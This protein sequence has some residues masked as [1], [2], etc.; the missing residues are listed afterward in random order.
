MLSRCP[1]GPLKEYWTRVPVARRINRPSS[2]SPAR[3]AELG[4]IGDDGLQT[5]AIHSLTA[6]S[7]CCC[8]T[9]GMVQWESSLTGL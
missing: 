7:F 6:P 8:A 3:N 5:L 4:Q 9:T 1:R 2:E